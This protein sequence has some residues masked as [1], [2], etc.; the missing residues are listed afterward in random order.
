MISYIAGLGIPLM[1]GELKNEETSPS[2]SDSATQAT[3]YYLQGLD[4]KRDILVGNCPS[5]ILTI[6]G[7]ILSV[8]GVVIGD[9]NKN[10][11]AYEANLYTINIESE[12]SFKSFHR[13]LCCLYGALR[14]LKQQYITHLE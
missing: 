11:V 9:C 14:D 5:L 1:I 8:N 6:R 12:E 13:L 4:S 2:K 3:T 10:A 7:T